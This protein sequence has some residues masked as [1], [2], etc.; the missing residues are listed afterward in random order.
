MVREWRAFGM[1]MPRAL[2]PNGA[3]FQ[4]AENGRF[5]FDVEIRLRLIGRLVHYRGWLAPRA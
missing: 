1:P 2:A 5:H 3:A 4:S